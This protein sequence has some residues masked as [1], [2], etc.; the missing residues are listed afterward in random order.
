MFTEAYKFRSHQV[1][2]TARYKAVVQSMD[3]AQNPASLPEEEAVTT[4]KNYVT[5]EIARLTSAIEKIQEEQ[6]YPTVF[7]KWL[8]HYLFIVNSSLAIT[9]HITY[10]VSCI[11]LCGVVA[12]ISDPQSREPRV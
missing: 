4:L 1:F 10:H 6:L 2:T 12:R 8:S 3:K 11:L 9:S 5:S 7:F